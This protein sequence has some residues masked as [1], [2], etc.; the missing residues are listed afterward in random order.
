M[1]APYGFRLYVAGPEVGSARA[2]P[3]VRE[4][5]DACL[6]QGYALEVVDLRAH[7][8]RAQ[9]DRVLAVPTLIRIAP[10]PVRRAVGSLRD[11]VRLAEALDLPAPQ[12]PALEASQQP[13]R[14]PA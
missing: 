11:A 10:V 14:F 1:S 2:E 8:E 12:R 6:P 13:F 3:D 9:A 7:P 4:A 5:L